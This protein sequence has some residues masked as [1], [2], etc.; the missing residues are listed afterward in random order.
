M[1]RPLKIVLRI[2][3]AC[4]VLCVLLIAAFLWIWWPSCGDEKLEE[5]R[6]LDGRHVAQLIRRNC[7]ATTPFVTLLFIDRVRRHTDSPSLSVARVDSV[8]MKWRDVDLLEVH[9][10][11]GEIGRAETRAGDV[12]IND[13][14]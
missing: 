11:G 2:A 7:G 5:R 6:S 13:V 12:R 10:W 14:K 9:V 8:Q 1:T 4:L 3:G